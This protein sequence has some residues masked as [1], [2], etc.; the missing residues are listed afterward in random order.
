MCNENP[1][2]CIILEKDLKELESL[3]HSNTTSWILITHFLEKDRD[4]DKKV[5]AKIKKNQNITLYKDSD[6]ILVKVQPQS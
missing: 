1:R 2:W 5:L 3:S 4:R 6:M